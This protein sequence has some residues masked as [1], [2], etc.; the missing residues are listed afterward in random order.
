MEESIGC[1]EKKKFV[2]VSI[3]PPHY[4]EKHWF[5]YNLR[6]VLRMRNIAISSIINTCRI[7]KLSAHAQYK[8]CFRYESSSGRHT[9]M[10]SRVK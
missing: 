3:F 10:N 2:E 9:G 6:F 5:N 1:K 7:S 8:F 4:T